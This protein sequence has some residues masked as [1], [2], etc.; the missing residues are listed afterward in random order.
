MNVY[1][2]KDITW[3]PGADTFLY[4]SF[5]NQNLNDDSWNNRNWTWYSWA[6]SYTTWVKSYWANNWNRWI[7]IPSFIAW[8]F[9]LS[10]WVKP[11]NNWLSIQT[12]FW[13]IDW[14]STY[15]RIH[16][17]M[18]NSWQSNISLWLS[19]D[20]TYSA[21]QAITWNEW[22][23]IV[24][25]K[26]SWVFRLY[27]NKNL[28]LTHTYNYN[29][30]TWWTWTIWNWYKEDRHVTWILDEVILETRWWTQEE[31]NDYYD[32]TASKVYGLK[33]AYIGEVWNPWGGTVWYWTFN[34]QNANQIT[35]V[36]WNWNNITGGVMPTYT[37]VLWG[38]YAW[39]YN[40]VSSW[41][42]QG[43]HWTIDSNKFTVMLWL[44]VLATWQQYI[45]N[46]TTSSSGNSPALI[47]WYNSWQIELY[48]YQNGNTYRSTIKSS[49]ALDTW[50]CVWFTRN[51]TTMKTYLNGAYV[52]SATIPV[53][54]WVA[55]FVLGS[56][57]NST[58][59]HWQIGEVVLKSW[60]EEDLNYM[61]SYYNQT[62]SLY[63]IS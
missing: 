3:H 7:A 17:H 2:Y 29:N 32:N 23:H 8:D 40:N 4:Y 57:W 35:D 63:W 56:V 55:N 53:V 27:K 54:S 46:M 14:T 38:N 44:K 9:T 16:L 24:L 31:I 39:N 58:R 49:T 45:I 52:T 59:F 37:Q 6:W 43:Y 33:Q 60:V 61:S 1:I 10:I 21:S 15:W 36:S 41:D 50:Y 62:K 26:I 34:D 13:S 18:Y 12:L 20:G 25:T 51:W 48:S 42:T 22:N 5:D 47:Y 19:Q 28:I 30:Q 11:T